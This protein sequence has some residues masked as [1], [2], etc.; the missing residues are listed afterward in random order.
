M[1]AGLERLVHYLRGVQLGIALGGGAARGMAHL[2]VLQALENAG[3]CFDTFAGTSSGAMTGIV[4]ASGRSPEYCIQHF[5]EDLRLKWFYRLAPGGGKWFMFGKYRSGAWDG[6][7]RKYLFDW[8]LEQ[9]CVPMRAV[10]V[11]LVGA[12][13]VVRD[14]GDAVQAILES[15]NLPVLSKPINRDGMALV[16]GGILN[17]L[18]ANILVRSGATFVVA[19]N[20]SSQLKQVFAGNTPETP[21]AKMKS[22]STVQTVL[23]M[24]S[25]QDKNLSAIG[26]GVADFTIAPDVSAIDISEFTHTPEI[27]A[28][29][30][31]AAEQAMPQLRDMLYKVDPQ[32]FPLEE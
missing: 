3:L 8:R 25:V 11:D 31:I 2:G 17:T 19:V 23:R 7:L 13:E 28:I 10:T 22:G 15:I 21:T 5:T 27:A 6:M 9:F 24:L 30:R 4:Y 12:R 1:V 16:D 14:Q 20:V 18:P 29:G 26:A 32:L